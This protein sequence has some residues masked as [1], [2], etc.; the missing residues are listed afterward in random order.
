MSVSE[1]LITI[2]E[3]QQKVYTSGQYSVYQGSEYMHPT[4]SGEVI[5]IDDMSSVP[6]KVTVGKRSK[7]LFNVNTITDNRDLEAGTGKLYPYGDMFVSDFIPITANTTFTGNYIK[8]CAY[9][10]SNKQYLSD[11]GSKSSTVARTLTTPAN[12]CYLRFSYFSETV[13]SNGVQIELGSIASAYTPYIENFED[14]KIKKFSKNLLDISTIPIL[15]PNPSD[16][17]N[18][19]VDVEAG[20]FSF[21]VTMTAYSNGLTINAYLP[22][23][24]YFLSGSVHTAS[25]LKCGVYIRK[26]DGSVYLNYAGNGFPPN[27]MVVDTEGIWKF[28]FYRPYNAPV[29]DIVTYSNVMLEVGETR[30]EYQPY[31]EPVDVGD[32]FDSTTDSITLIPD[33]T[34]GYLDCQYCRDIDKG[35]TEANSAGRE[36]EWNLMW[37]AIQR[38]GNRT[39]YGFAFLYWY[40][41]W[42]YPK[43]DIVLAGGDSSM[44]EA[45]G[46]GAF[47]G[48]NSGG[49]AD[50]DLSARF[51][52]CGVTLDTSKCKGLQYFMHSIKAK[53]IPTLDF[54]SA[55]NLY[56]AFYYTN[57]QIIDKLIS[58]ETSAFVANTFQYNSNLT[59][60][61]EVEG[62]IAKSINFQHSPLDVPTMNR[63]IACLKDYS[64]TS[65][66]YTLTLKADRETMLTDEEKAVATNKGWTL[67]WS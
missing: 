31:K 66:T 47:R 41:Y 34:G 5:R 48:F 16:M 30:T 8:N 36:A 35:I 56:M 57:V 59:T 58:S 54:S 12:T 67:V 2:A 17:K 7:N 52:E 24:T 33:T 15:N 13:G 37:D 25:G 10:D 61:T 27:P 9:Y 23:G 29:G 65:G 11:I 51:E 39:D 49:S 50:F 63:I 32:T 60:I 1:K 64:S 21:E 42:F 4:V 53:R 3:N 14:V 40:S 18:V 44:G 55:T 28:T 20:T 43:Y 19:V 38:N 22:I 26:P 6:H 45:I 62:V 46:T